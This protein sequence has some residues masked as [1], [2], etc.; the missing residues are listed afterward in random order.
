MGFGS[1]TQG[2]LGCFT[3]PGKGKDLYKAYNPK[4]KVS[5]SLYNP[6]NYV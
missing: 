5:V 6:K 1:S 4:I 3:W 2:N